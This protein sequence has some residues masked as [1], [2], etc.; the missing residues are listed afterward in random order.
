MKKFLF[1]LMLLFCNTGIF[2]QYIRF[3][4]QTCSNYPKSEAQYTHDV[5]QASNGLLILRNRQENYPD[6]YNKIHLEKTDMNGNILWSR[7]FSSSQGAGLGQIVK[8]DENSFYIV[9]VTSHGG[10]DV[11]YN[12]YENTINIW[13]I[14]IDSSGN[15][16]WD[17]VIG[18]TGGDYPWDIAVT[19]DGGIALV[20]TFAAPYADSLYEGDATKYYGFWDF[21][22]VKLNK[23]DGHMEWDYTYGSSM[24][25]YSSSLIATADGG[26]LAGG[27]SASAPDGNVAC[28]DESGLILTQ[29]VLIKY[30]AQGEVEWQKCYGSSDDDG[31][32]CILET[33]DGY[34]IGGG[35]RGEDLDLE[36]AGWHEGYDH[37]GN[38]E[39]D[40]WIFKINK[41]GNLQWSKCFGGSEYEN[42]HTLFQT[43]KGEII[44]FGQTKSIDGDVKRSYPDMNWE[45]LDIWMLKLSAQG[46]L[47]WQRSIGT[48]SDQ[49]I[50]NG[51][52]MIDDHN[53]VIGANTHFGSSGDLTC[54]TTYD[55]TQRSFSWIAHFTDTTNGYG[56]GVYEEEA[57]RYIK[58]HPNPA[59]DYIALEIPP[60]F[61]M[62]HT[63][64]EITDIAG[65]KMQSIVLSGNKPYLYT[66]DLPAGLYLLRLINKQGFVSKR[67][68]KN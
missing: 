21:W 13:V 57:N 1:A 48:G 38:R 32:S 47:L 39:D 35:S 68:V 27:T 28:I 52:A 5:V 20:A 17:K 31:V 56:L 54:G 50:S 18:G 42:P 41:Q 37:L 62:K 15:K 4:W 34:I 9:G 7:Y 10:G 24:R 63:I 36:G 51:I 45:D 12:P 66:G 6:G 43:S 60:E 30:N 23:D 14:K 58:V 44:V 49:E 40:V 11:T 26:C 3:N 25:E 2:A 61:D 19:N 46:D 65:R 16:L 33:D 22:T 55:S 59:T 67:F 8:A 64:A 29:G 53:F